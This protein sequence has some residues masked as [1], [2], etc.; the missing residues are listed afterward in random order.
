[1]LAY[2]GHQLS[3]PLF[4][5][6]SNYWKQLRLRFVNT[7]LILM[8]L[9]TECLLNDKMNSWQLQNTNPL[10]GKRPWLKST[11]P[12]VQRIIVLLHHIVG[13]CEAQ[14]V[15]HIGPHHHDR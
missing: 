5:F 15:R 7:S 12:L 11:A 10:L 4:P 9:L 3:N 2:S 13:Q 14:S 8:L 1:M 6:W